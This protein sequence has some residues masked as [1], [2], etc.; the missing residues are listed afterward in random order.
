MPKIPKGVFKKTYHNPNSRDAPNY[1]FV[2]E[3]AQTP[4]A[5]STLEVLQICPSQ[6]NGLLVAI[7]STDSVNLTTKFD[8]S[9]VKP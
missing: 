8:L 9:D 7:D 5:M 1:S 2:E 6:C 3:L 4:C